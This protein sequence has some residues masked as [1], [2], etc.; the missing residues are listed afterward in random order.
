MLFCRTLQCILP[1]CSRVSETAARL[2]ALLEKEKPANMAPLG[3]QGIPC[4]DQ[5]A[6]LSFYFLSPDSG[7]PVFFGHRREWARRFPNRC[8]R[9]TSFNRVPVSSSSGKEY[10]YIVV[11]MSSRGLGSENLAYLPA[12]A[13]TVRADHASS[14]GSWKSPSR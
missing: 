1:F 5:P 6:N 2:N 3:D 7:P 13:C 10:L 8:K 14:A 11:R 12:R 4:A 9:S